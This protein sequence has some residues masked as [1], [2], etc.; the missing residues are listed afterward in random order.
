MVSAR[1]P[2]W[3]RFVI[4]AGLVVL[5]LGAGLFGYRWYSRPT[6]LTIAV[7]SLDREAT[8][9]VAA[10]ASRLAAVNAPV[11]LKLVET[12]SA[13]DAADLFAAE[14]VDLAVVRG[15]VGDL[16]QA[17]AVVVLAHAVVLLATPPG[18]SITDIAG[19]KRTS[20]GVI[21]GEIN[22]KI[23]NVLS[24]EYG[25]ARANVTF[26]NLQPPDARRALDTKEVR[27][28]LIVVPL[29]EKYLALL[30][31]LFLQTPKTAPVLLP[32]DAA[33]AI[34]AKQRAFESFDVP[35]GTL[36]GSPP[37]PS[38]DITTLRV[39]FYVVAQKQLSAKVAG[40]LADALMKARRDLL[41]ELP[42]LSQMTAPSTDS[43]AF[44]PVHPGAAAFYNGTQQSFLDEWGN[45]IFLAPMIL[46]GL[47]SVL[48]AA[49]KFLRA[50]DPSKDE[51]DLD[52]LYAL[53]ARIR[54][55]GAE[56]E[57]SEIEAEIDRVLQAQRTKTAAGD[58]N[59]LDVTT[60]NVAAHRLQ[61]LIHDRR[62]LLSALPDSSA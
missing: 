44:L 24:D 19:L 53:G 34:A 5:V 49:W 12:T 9:L 30:R 38:E 35:K 2:I 3:F 42:V 32:I 61:S 23:V 47:V 56:T 14:K 18:S 45:A 46:G 31:G 11:R 50:G 13:V 55:T 25:L 6:V 41:G 28:I 17:Q 22:R 43:D 8:R 21:G 37:V 27:A 10:L 52:S 60:L 54:T 4:V 48:A 1:M 29:A 15:D 33:G 51:H 20:V 59:A 40:G 39:S 7:G 62:I 58:E 36:R 26:R 16:S 57:L